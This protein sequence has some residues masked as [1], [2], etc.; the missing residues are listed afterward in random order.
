MPLRIVRND[1]TKMNTDAI[2]NTANPQPT[3]AAGTDRAVYTAAGADKLLSERQKIGVMN[4]GDAAITP[5]FALPAKYIIHTVG[6]VWEDGEHGEEET[7]ASCYKNCLKI[8]KEH[9]LKSIAF[10]MISTGV[11]GFPKE[12]AIHVALSCFSSFLMKEDM[13]IY[14]VVFSRGAFTLSEKLFPGIDAYIDDH[15][16]RTK[17]E[18]EYS[19]CAETYEENDAYRREK[20]LLARRRAKHAKNVY[21]GSALPPAA[22]EKAEKPERTLEDILDNADETFQQML[23]RLISERGMT[24]VEVYKKAN[25]DKKLFAK[26]KANENYMPKKVTALALCIALKLNFDEAKDLI[27]RAGY[28]FSPSSKTDLI[29]RYFIEHEAYDVMTIDGVLFE[30]DL[31]MLTYYPD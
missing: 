10:P 19:V 22:M 20:E 5:G 14:L 13:D 9:K 3:Y 21:C 6:P 2:V 11:Y 4:P 24:N 1:I 23:F 12:K 17:E 18:E 7:L 16:V 26:I 15:Y 25:L 28:T 8:A 31:P 29:V 27:G 30:H